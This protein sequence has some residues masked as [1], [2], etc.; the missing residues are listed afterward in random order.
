MSVESAVRMV[1]QAFATPDPRS[2]LFSVRE[3][4]EALAD[5]LR[6]GP[7]ARI[8]PLSLGGLVLERATALPAL[9]TPTPLVTLR[10][11]AWLVVTGGEQV[12]VDAATDD[13]FSATPFGERVRSRHWWR[14]RPEVG[15][16]LKDAL[17]AAGTTPAAIDRV[18]LTT[19]RY[20]AL[21][22][23]L[24][25]LPRAKV[26]VHPD[27]HARARLPPQVD[28][29]AYE[30]AV[31][32]AHPR[33]SLGANVALEGLVAVATHGLGPSLTVAG[34][35]E[36]VRVLSPHGVAIDCWSPYESRLPGL[37]EALRLRELEAVGRGDADPVGS[38]IA[39]GFE[40]TLAD[41]RKD[42]PA[43]FEI[44]PSLELSPTLLSPLA[45]RRSR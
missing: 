18:I 44:T 15:V 41:R 8:T 42:A 31:I 28:E 45:A 14:G 12:L 39:M 5:A 34:R 3:A 9:R 27:E 40:R 25:A 6:R 30:R 29:A 37:R 35:D 10:R 20:Q 16:T 21:G 13:A 17:R 26:H 7:A 38:S 1:D 24:E 43:F 19:L 4:G 11:R 36:A 33:L 32:G 22:A 23:L 2:R